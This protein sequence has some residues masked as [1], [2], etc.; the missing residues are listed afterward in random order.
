[1]E[2]FI[3][4]VLLAFSAMFSATE[5]AYSSANKIRLKNLAALGDLKAKRAIKILEHFDKSLTAIL[6]GNNIVNISSASIATVLF[7]R[8]FGASSVGVA[9]II[10]TLAVLIFGEVIPKSIA[11]E[12]AESIAM[13][14]S[15]P[16]TFLTFILKPIVFFFTCLKRLVSK[17]FG[18][19]TVQPSVTEEELIYLVEEIEDQGVLEKQESNLV[20]SALEFDEITIGEIL[21]PRVNIVALEI[22]DSF[23][24]IRDVFFKENY[25]RIP[26]YNKTIDNIVGIIHQ[27]DFFNLYINNKESSLNSILK[28]PLYISEHKRISEC[29]IEMQKAKTHMAVVVDQYGGTDGIVTLEDVLEELVGEIYDESDEDDIS[30]VKLS[31][32]VWEVSADL[33]ITD[34]LERMELPENLIEADCNSIGGWLMDLAECI[35]DEGFSV[36]NGIFKMTVVSADEQRLKRILVEVDNITEDSD[37]KSL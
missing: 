1:M 27:N 14:M 24:S 28:K 33:S 29:L 34:M 5:T 32:N 22:D 16:L 17:F 19:N 11:A 12:H 21:V 13:F 9:T 31:D 7:T 23:E 37:E 30:F 35:P 36:T 20:R 25:S 26:I 3:I 10:M 6:V 8:V 18:T 15:A 4:I 2:I